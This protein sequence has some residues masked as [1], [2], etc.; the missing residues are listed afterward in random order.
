MTEQTDYTIDEADMPLAQELSNFDPVYDIAGPTEVVGNVTAPPTLSVT[1]LPHHKRAPILA[2]LAREPEVCRPATEQRL[3][4]EALEQ[5]KLDLIVRAGPGPGATEYQR[6]VCGILHEI[7]TLNSER[8]RLAADLA[9]VS[10]WVTKV[11]PA[12]GVATPVAIERMQGT[13]REGWQQ[14]INEID[15]HLALLE[16]PE[17]ERRKA[18][19]LFNSVQTA[20]RNREALE[21]AAEVKRRAA[22]MVRDERVNR[23]AEVR[24]RMTR[25]N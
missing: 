4:K 18:R 16:G 23:A 19:A 17:G 22:Q 9:E 25:D 6:E 14:R 2:A 12:T 1:C 11:D 7:H 8:M 10:R 21:D 3:V 15:H 20:K 13:R 24:F 5:N